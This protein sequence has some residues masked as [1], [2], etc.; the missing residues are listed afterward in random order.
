MWGEPTVQRWEP[1]NGN[2]TYPECKYSCLWVLKPKLRRFPTDKYSCMYICQWH[3][4]L[5]HISERQKIHMY[6]SWNYLTATHYWFINYLLFPEVTSSPTS[7]GDS[8][9]A[10]GWSSSSPQAGTLHMNL[11]KMK[12]EQ[13]T[14]QHGDKELES[15]YFEQFVR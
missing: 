9:R 10:D 6:K 3:L 11:L 1:R 4:N 13:I 12:L 7:G 2:R 5:G 15:I 8:Q 14:R